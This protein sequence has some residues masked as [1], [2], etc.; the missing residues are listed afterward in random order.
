MKKCLI[1]ISAL[2]MLVGCKEIEGVLFVDQ[3]LQ[4]M[5]DGEVDAVIVPGNYDVEIEDD[6]DDH[7]LKIKVKDA[8]DGDDYKFRYTYPKGFRFPEN[9]NY[10]L[11]AS[12]SNQMYDMYGVN[13]KTESLSGIRDDY[14]RCSLPPYQECWYDHYGRPRCR[15]VHRDGYRRVEYRIRTTNYT[16]DLELLNGEQSMATMTGDKSV[17]EREYIHQ[18]FCR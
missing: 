14:E 10:E 4:I 13:T 1:F 2:F 12:E 7:R 18:G 15:M 3:A 5:E 8:V 16:V 11:L 9:G 17:S 6:E